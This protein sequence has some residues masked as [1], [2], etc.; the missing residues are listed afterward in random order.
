[1]R[2]SAA[3]LTSPF[4]KG[5]VE[6]FGKQLAL[7]QRAIPTGFKTWDGLC[8]ETGGKGFP[9]WYY[10]V[11][12]G[13]SNAGKTHCM[14]HMA[15]TAW[16]AG[17][18]VGIV[19]MEVPTKGMLRRLYADVTN[20]DYSDFRP[21]NWIKDGPGNTRL[22]VDQVD[23]YGHK[24]QLIIAEHEYGSPTIHELMET[25]LRLVDAGC[26]AIYV[27]H[28]QL[29]KSAGFKADQI[30]AAATEVSECLRVF[31]HK[32]PCLV[33]ALSQLHRKAAGDRDRPPIMQDLYGGTSIESNANQVVLLE[34]CTQKEIIKDVY[35]GEPGEKEYRK[36]TYLFLDKN[37]DGRNRINIPV[38]MRFR[39]GLWVQGN[40]REWP[41]S[42][43]LP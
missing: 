13:A 15:R 38:E 4:F 37:R 11:V 3:R 24:G 14:K 39:T 20:F 10:V 17:N 31:A 26:E 7:P 5:Q 41:E 25:C 43:R 30:A 9:D 32:T 36:R 19:T 27:D 40:V 2:E 1:M 35:G 6:D 8:D 18:R 33:V 34:H 16:Q 28:L 22:L 12:G 21:Q 29:I 42:K 23:T